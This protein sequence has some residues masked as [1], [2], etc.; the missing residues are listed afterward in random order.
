MKE[1]SEGKKIPVSLESAPE[2]VGG[3]ISEIVIGRKPP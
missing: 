2:G 3:K 1:G